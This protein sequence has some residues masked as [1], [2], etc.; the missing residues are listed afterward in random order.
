[1]ISPFKRSQ[2]VNPAKKN[3]KRTGRITDMHHNW[4]TLPH[5]MKL[6]EYVCVVF[7]ICSMSLCLTLS[8]LWLLVSSLEWFGGL[9]NFFF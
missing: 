1:M 4:N 8:L 2:N 5:D 6:W 3:Y 7:G 9:G